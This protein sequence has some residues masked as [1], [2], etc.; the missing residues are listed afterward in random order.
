[1]NDVHLK[2]HVVVHEV[3]Q[4]TLVGHDASHLSCGKED[5]LGLLFGKELLDGILPGQVEFLMRSCYDI[6]V[7][8]PLQL[9]DYSRADHA[10]VACDIN[11]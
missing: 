6:G 11:L 8:L 7:S 3:C 9:P 2:Y 4:S 1:M 10:S 5:V